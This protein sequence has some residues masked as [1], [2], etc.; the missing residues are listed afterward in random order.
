MAE[1]E[2]SVIEEADAAGLEEVEAKE[3]L[4]PQ[5]IPFY[6]KRMF[7]IALAV[8]GLLLLLVMVLSLLSGDHE[9]Y[10]DIALDSDF[11]NRLEKKKPIPPSKLE[12]LI[13]KANLLYSQG[14]KKE[15]LKLFKQIATQSESISFYNLGVARMK[16][17][18][19]K[20]ALE[21]FKKAIAQNDRLCVSAINSA[22]CALELQNKKLFD[23]YIHLAQSTLIN[24]TNSPL[25]SYYMA[26]INYYKDYDLEALSA[27]KHKSS[28]FYIDTQ[29]YIHAKLA[30]ALN[31]PYQAITYL[32]KAINDDDLGALG[33]LYARVGNL[34]LA[35]KNLLKAIDGGYAVIKNSLALA[36]VYM[37]LGAVHD[38]QLIYKMLYDKDLKNYTTLYPIE[39]FIA[40][41]T[42]DL[43]A[44]Q[45]NYLKRSYFPL[46]TNLEILM[47]FAPFKIF[48]AQS[49]IGFIKKG[50]A[51]IFIED[52]QNARNYLKKSTRFSAVNR[53]IA[54]GIEYALQHKLYDAKKQFEKMI[55]LYP[56]HSILNYNLGLI[57]AKLGNLYQANR[58][59]TKSYN[60]DAK[61]YM[62]GIFTILTGKLTGN[63]NKK[64]K[65]LFKENLDTEIETADIALIRALYDFYEKNYPAV[66]NWSQEQKVS[67]TLELALMHITAKRI[68]RL[69]LEK[70]YAL[71]L[72]QK[73]PNDVLAHTLYIHTF[74][75][76]LT[77]KAFTFKSLEYL[78]KLHL[79]LNDLFY[80]SAITKKMFIEY[81]FVSGHLFDLAQ[82]LEKQ[83]AIES[84]NIIGIMQAL[85]LAKN[86]LTQFEEAFVLYNQL[87]DTYK[88]KDAKTLFNA[89]VAA[90]GSQHHANAI[91]LLELANLH[92]RHHAESRYALALLYLEA[93]NYN[94]AAIQLNRILEPEFKSK[95]FNFMIDSK[96]LNSKLINP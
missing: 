8:S 56:K 87:I 14:H 5:K 78:Q 46:E 65:Q 28:N 27:L 51:N 79:S 58:Y 64:Q 36:H 15:A 80:G 83:L 76:H 84:K 52:M 24:E 7:I 40:P 4:S 71:A 30:A 6:K 70:K 47:H 61:N 2:L 72:T 37:K 96:S 90:T 41:K 43:K 31:D 12:L 16:N 32:E 85:A 42:F 50:S 88:Q 38:A 94:A 35:K 20:E 49:T 48:D 74:F 89:A 93:K 91:A 66:I 69:D 39:V 77:P 62:A 26:L 19:F 22:V 18:Q 68:N 95:F 57:Y 29:N 23:Y 54:D 21:A 9:A 73:A 59:F 75:R 67:T 33:M 1:E 60:L 13:K 55:K 86:Y 63:I 3:E 17:G 82:K 11:S 44:V 25:Y 45:S 10:D 81:T 34:E 92:N 53:G